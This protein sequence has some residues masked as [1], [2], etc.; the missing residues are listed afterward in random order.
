[1]E[2]AETTTNRRRRAPSFRTD[3]S[4]EK[5]RVP[6][7]G[8]GTSVEKGYPSRGEHVVF[9]LILYRTKGELSNEVEHAADVFQFFLSCSMRM[10][11]PKSERRHEGSMDPSSSSLSDY[12]TWL[13]LRTLRKNA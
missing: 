5:R 2:F 3:P 8:R 4:Q 10:L 7:S 1:M 12:R 9:F 13:A 11:A 6:G